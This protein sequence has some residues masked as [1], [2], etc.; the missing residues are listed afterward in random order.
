MAATATQQVIHN[1]PRNFVAKYTIG[2]TTGDTTKG[3]LVDASAIDSTLG[4]NALRLEKAEWAL[5]GF[6]CNLQWD[7]GP[8]VDLIEL[9]S[10]FGR[11]DFSDIGGIKN[12]ATLQS[13]DV[14]FTTTNY[15]A[16]GN[17]GHIVLEFKKRARANFAA[18]G[19][20]GD[21]EV[22]AGSIAITGYAP[23]IP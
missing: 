11:L 17:G 5:T 10:G 16:S 22:G 1:G 7:G 13:G 8:D 18:G 2:G 21:I 6:S 19:L 23:T 3:T 14:L 9:N 15:T 20:G 4:D 12:N